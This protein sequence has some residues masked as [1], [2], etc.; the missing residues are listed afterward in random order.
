[1]TFCV[2]FPVALKYFRRILA[3]KYG[4]IHD[5]KKMGKYIGSF[6]MPSDFS[7]RIFFSYMTNILDTFHCFLFY[8]ALASIY[9]DRRKETK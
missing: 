1:M 3:S 5:R 9:N 7:F 4:G 8:K 2:T 6:W